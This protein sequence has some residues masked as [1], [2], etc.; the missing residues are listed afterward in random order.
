MKNAKSNLMHC[1]PVDR[2][3]LSPIWPHT[4]IR[5]TTVKKTWHV[6][7]RGTGAL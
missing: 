3:G 7:K 4:E 5:K 2:V 1:R 6:S